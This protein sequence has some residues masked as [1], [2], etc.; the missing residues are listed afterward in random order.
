MIRHALRCPKQTQKHNS[1][2]QDL[3]KQ[4]QLLFVWQVQIEGE[5]YMVYVSQLF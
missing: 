5:L 2:M 4:V 1:H 3:F